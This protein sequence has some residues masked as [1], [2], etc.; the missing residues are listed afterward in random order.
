MKT[1]N[2]LSLSEPIAEL[3]TVKQVSVSITSCHMH[4]MAGMCC[5]IQ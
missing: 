2:L 5:C 1:L 3:K 4:A